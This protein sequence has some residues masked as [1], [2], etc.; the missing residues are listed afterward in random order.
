MPESFRDDPEI[1]DDIAEQHE[2]YKV[3]FIFRL[4]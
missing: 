1:A 3:C 2:H 4:V